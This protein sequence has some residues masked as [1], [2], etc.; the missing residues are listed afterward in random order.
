[1]RPT[2]A[3]ARETRR[4]SA[5]ETP[6]CRPAPPGCASRSFP[7]RR[8]DVPEGRPTWGRGL[9]A[10]SSM[11]H[12]AGGQVLDVPKLIL[13]G[14]SAAG[15]DV[16][17]RRSALHVDHLLARP[18]VFLRTAVA[19]QAPFH[20]QR[21]HLVGEGHLVDSAVT[22]GAADPLVDVNAMVEVDEAGKV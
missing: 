16:I 8:R 3:L 18:Q 2:V 10:G 5:P 7:G 1:T 11:T 20:Q 22:A 6:R 14:Q 12:R 13:L 15:F 4:A 9:F 17:V 19:V 21:G